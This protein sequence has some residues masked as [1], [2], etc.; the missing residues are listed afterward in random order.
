MNA[1]QKAKY[2]KRKYDEMSN[3]RIPLINVSPYKVDKINIEIELPIQEVEELGEKATI[4]L[5]KHEFGSKI[6]EAIKDYIVIETRKDYSCLKYRISA[7]LR[8]A[9]E[10]ETYVQSFGETMR[11]RK[12]KRT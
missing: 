2:Y 7:V 4:E 8:V 12:R 1:R 3:M 5:M 11:E 6:A 10:K 9:T